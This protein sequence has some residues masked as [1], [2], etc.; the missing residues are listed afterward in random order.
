M[1]DAWQDEITIL[2]FV[3]EDAFPLTLPMVQETGECYQLDYRTLAARVGRDH[4]WQEVGEIARRAI[5]KWAALDEDAG[6]ERTYSVWVGHKEGCDRDNGVARVVLLYVT[7]HAVRGGADDGSEDE[8]DEGMTPFDEVLGEVPEYIRVESG[9]A[10]WDGAIPYYLVQ[11]RLATCI[12]P[13]DSRC[14]ALVDDARADFWQGQ[15][16]LQEVGGANVF[17]DEES[18]EMSRGALAYLRVFLRARRVNCFYDLP[19]G[20]DDAPLPDWIR[21]Y[22]ASGGVLFHTPDWRNEQ[23]TALLAL[24]AE[25]AL[26]LSAPAG[27]TVEPCPGDD[28]IQHMLQFQDEEQG[29]LCLPFI[30][31]LTLRGHLEELASLAVQDRFPLYVFEEMQEGQT[32]LAGVRVFEPPTDARLSFAR[33]VAEAVR[34]YAPSARLVSPAVDEASGDDAGDVGPEDDSEVESALLGL[35]QHEQRVWAV[36]RLCQTRDAQYAEPICEAVGKLSWAEVDEVWQHLPLLGAGAVEAFATLASASKKKSGA[37]C[38]MR[39]LGRIPCERSLQVLSSLVQTSGS[40]AEPVEALVELGEYA[41]PTLLELSENAKADVRQMAAF[42]LG[43]IGA[44]AGRPALVEMAQSDRSSKVK[45]VAEKALA[46]LD[47]DEE[48]ELDLRDFYGN[49]ELQ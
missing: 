2:P 46:W 3:P 13:N 12:S 31:G 19:E 20:G 29:D 34:A 40:K 35:K 33:F 36:Q 5:S 28:T 49:I 11:G 14:E 41:V 32:R 7:P 39:A 15:L 42:A 21:D 10:A 43:K 4:V 6:I 47:G 23:A 38:G 45:E 30:Y 27:W 25:P 8:A 37:A 17:V 9:N 1:P 26:V 16:L 48:C 24:T 44:P 22:F 18:E